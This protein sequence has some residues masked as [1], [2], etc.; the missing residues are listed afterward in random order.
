M[1][2]IDKKRLMTCCKAMIIILLCTM[3]CAMVCACEKKVNGGD[4]LTPVAGTPTPSEIEPSATPIYEKTY[5]Y[6][7]YMETMPDNFGPLLR[8]S[9]EDRYISEYCEMGFVDASVSDNNDEFAWIYEMADSITDI[10][11][12]YEYAAEMGITAE[13]G[14]VFRIEL[15]KLAV[16]ENGTP[17]NADT[18]IYSMKAL[19]DSDKKYDNALEYTEGKAAILNAAD[20]YNNDRAGQ[21]RYLC[22]SEMGFSSCAEAISAGYDLYVDISF[23]GLQTSDGSTIVSINDETQ[24]LTEDTGNSATDYV[25]PA[26]IYRTYLADGAK[27]SEYAPYYIFCKDGVVK[28]AEW[29]EVGLIKESEYTLIYITENNISEFDFLCAM[30]SNWIIYNGIY[31]ISPE[32]YG[33]STETYMSYGPYKLEG[34]ENDEK[35]ILKKNDKWYGCND[36]KHIGQYQTTSIICTIV[37]NHETAMEMFL[38][39]ELDGIELQENDIETY[40]NSDH[41][42][43]SELSYTMRW[44]FATDL[45]ALITLEEEAADGCNKRVLYYDD[46]RK[47][48]SLA[49]KRD[50]LC[51]EGTTGYIPAYG[52]YNNLYCINIGKSSFDIYRNTDKAKEAI[53][54]LYGLTYG[55][56]GDFA[57][58]DE[59]YE[60]VNGYD[61]YTASLLL[62]SVYEKALADGNYTDGQQIQI[63]VM[64]SSEQS[65]SEK[66]LIQQDLMNSF[67][68]EA[69]KGTGFENLINFTFL[70]GSQK[71]YE[72]VAEGLIEMIRGAWGGIIFDPYSA[73]RCYTEPD[74]MGG[75]S[76]INESCGWNPC[77]E[78]IYVSFDFDGDGNVETVNDTY[79]NWA[80]ALNTDSSYGGYGDNE[81]ASLCIMASLEASVL[82][83]YNCIPWATETVC[84]LYSRQIE[85]YT[86]DYNIMYGYGELRLLRYNYDDLAWNEYIL[87]NEGTIVY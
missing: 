31:D 48:L 36:G 2:I 65:L 84:Q 1:R 68:S 50:E 78:T 82:S 12:S 15:N 11:G 41:I 87:E 24:Y 43:I 17:I 34:I 80:K 27:Y 62:Q 45:Q 47:A 49:M 46:F 6:N 70:C 85:Y 42:I 44:I 76:A 72:E 59:A 52:L 61:V 79:Q 22:L 9:D 83:E 35:I 40:R 20:Y 86:Y 37:F 5:T 58:I 30:T 55:E 54:K 38:K 7:D 53:L 32:E 63:N 66:D 25:T 18:Y 29:S 74:Y 57:T 10:T 14:R 8:S 56:D 81:E 71:R 67:I 19:L 77:I 73:I 23:L 60:L 51:A 28:A 39:G 21:D 13:E 26:F 3:M 64:V 75:I 69:A 4:V 16:W 33:M